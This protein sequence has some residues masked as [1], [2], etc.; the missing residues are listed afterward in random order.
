[1]AAG[2]IVLNA[3]PTAVADM[4]APVLARLSALAPRPASLEASG[5]APEL[6]ADLALKHL[7]RAGSLPSAALCER[8]GMVS[9]VLEP[10]VQFLRQ[11]GRLQ[12]QARASFDNEVRLSLTERG[13]QGAQEALRRCGYVGPAPVPL[14]TYT[15]VVRAQTI[16]RRSLAR[17]KVSRAFRDII[18]ASDLCDRLGVAIASGRA[19]FIYGPAGSG[20]TYIASRLIAALPGEVLIPHAITVNDKVVRVFDAAVHDQIDL[21]DGN[22]RLLLAQGYDARFALCERPMIIVGGEM[23]EDMLDVQFNAGTSEYNAP[24]QMKSNGGVLV[25]DDLGRQRFMPQRLFD[26]WTVPLEQQVDH[27]SAGVDARFATPCDAVIVF[28][29]NLEP[30]ELADDAV[31]RRLGYKIQL[32]PLSVDLYTRV[33]AAVCEEMHTEFDPRLLNYALTKLYPPSRRPLLACHP[34][35]LICMALDKAAYDERNGPF[36]LDDLCWAWTNYF[37]ATEMSGDA[38]M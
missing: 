2:H 37:L 17:E 34:R 36:E 18:M 6:L 15:R 20:K 4:I 31:L 29:T 5:L 13:R 19:I 22:K 24:L 33:W 12:L 32:G 27:L 28:S 7:L 30:T 16:P 1:M 8:I 26:R 35:D 25:I 9:T 3:F 10:I 14:A 23:T 38:V 11:E 21:L